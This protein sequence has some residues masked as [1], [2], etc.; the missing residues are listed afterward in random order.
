MREPLMLRWYVPVVVAGVSMTVLILIT[1]TAAEFLTAGLPGAIAEHEWTVHQ[2]RLEETVSRLPAA[3]ADE[4]LR[5]AHAAAMRTRSWDGLIEVG[6]AF[7][8]AGASGNADL[9]GRARVAYLTALLRARKARSVDGVLR[10]AEGFAELGDAEVAERA[11]RTAED[12]A[13]TS[14]KAMDQ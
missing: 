8:R 4:R 14:R 7:R 10:A 3:A 1:L 5:A 2:A 9:R 13:R 11:F 6:N 12:L